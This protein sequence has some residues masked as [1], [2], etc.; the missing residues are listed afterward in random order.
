MMSAFESEVI[1]KFRLLDREAQKR[2]RDLIEREIDDERQD[3]TSSFD[4]DAWEAEVEAALITLSPDASGCMP[5]ASDL[6]NEVRE[7]RDADVLRSIGFG[8][9]A[10]DSAG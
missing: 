5:S 3:N 7:E 2:V 4:Y 8:D 10:G 6:V 9:S 1:E